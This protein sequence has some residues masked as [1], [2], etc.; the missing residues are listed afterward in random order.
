MAVFVP[1]TI[2]SLRSLP[3]R[4]AAALCGSDGGTGP[5][6]GSDGD[7][8]ALEP[9]VAVMVAAWLEPEKRICC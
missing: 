6:C 5:L 3:W 7:G 1:R 8:G 2:P 9:S 4:G